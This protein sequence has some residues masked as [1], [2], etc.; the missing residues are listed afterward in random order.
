MMGT[1]HAVSGGA[2]WLAGWS[3][4]AIADLA[5]PRLDVLTVGTLVC[6]GA[7]LYPDFDHPNSRIAKSG[8]WLTRKVAAL[9]GY[10]GRNIHAATKLDADRTDEDGHRTITHTFV[11]AALVGVICSGLALRFGQLACAVLVLFFTQLGADA[12]LGLLPA[13]RRRFKV[14]GVKVPKAP[15][16]AV[17]AAAGTYLLVP[18]ETWW[19][20]VAVGVGCAV[21]CLGDAITASG[22]PMLWPLPIPSTELRYV[23]GHRGRVRVRVWRTWY[24]VGTP[25]WMRFRVGSSAETAVTWSLVVLGMAAVGGIVYA[26]ATVA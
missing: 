12:A 6:A 10:V 13:R 16:I 19:L 24:L 5:Q 20:G 25:R 26:G 2:V 7:A 14:F 4:A 11:F 18:S 17:L 22:C 9:H 23:R 1:G 15:V 3:W 8:G 21:H